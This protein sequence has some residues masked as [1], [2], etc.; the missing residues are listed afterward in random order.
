MLLFAWYLALGRKNRDFPTLWL[1]VVPVYAIAALVCAIAAAPWWRDFD[2]SSRRE[3]LLMLALAC[4]PTLIGHSLLNASMHRIRGQV[5][6][7]A[8]VGQFV[9]AG[10]VAFALFGETPAPTF[11]VASS[12]A[13]MGMAVAVFSSPSAPP[14]LR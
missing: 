2:F 5:V 8:N 9:F 4:V 10:A 6:S 13:I 11:Y 1:Y 12:L 7:L 14:R 3:W